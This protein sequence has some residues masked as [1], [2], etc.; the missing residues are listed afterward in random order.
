M[1]ADVHFVLSQFMRWTDG[2]T[3]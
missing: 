1:W 3:N 2:R